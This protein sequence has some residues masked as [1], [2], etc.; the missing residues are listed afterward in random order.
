MD[1]FSVSIS[2]GLQ[3]GEPLQ[4][5]ILSLLLDRVQ[6]HERPEAS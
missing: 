1:A 5:P 2:I 6:P 3:Y 4:I